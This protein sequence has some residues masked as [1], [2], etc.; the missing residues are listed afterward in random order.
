MKIMAQTSATAASASNGHESSFEAIVREG[1]TEDWPLLCTAFAAHYIKNP[2][3]YYG[4]RIP[5]HTLIAKLESLL[6]SPNWQLLTACPKDNP[7][8][9]YG[10]LLYR[11]VTPNKQNPAIAWITVKPEYHRQGFAKALFR[12]AK[13]PQ[14]QIDCAFILPHVAKWADQHGYTLRFRP[15]LPDVELWRELN[16]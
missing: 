2:N 11:K 6:K 12:V 15:Y 13:I 9:V 16:K 14:G 8:E 10:M 4:Y 3:S 7:T 1:N 5:P